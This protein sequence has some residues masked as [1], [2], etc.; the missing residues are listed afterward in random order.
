MHFGLQVRQFNKVHQRL[1]LLRTVVISN[2]VSASQ[3]W[4]ARCTERTCL[5]GGYIAVH[6]ARP[7]NET[8][9][10]AMAVAGGGGGLLV[11]VVTPNYHGR[12]MVPAGL[13]RL[14]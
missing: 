1:G 12:L 13:E 3:P 6:M 11:Q 2:H 7:A 5:L 9:Y 8:C 10:L 4:H 14:R